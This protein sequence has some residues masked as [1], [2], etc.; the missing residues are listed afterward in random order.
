MNGI[1]LVSYARSLTH[2][3]RTPIIMLSASD[4]TLEAHR[5]GA[6]AFLRKPEDVSALAETIARLLSIE[7]K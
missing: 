6:N 5:A 4:Y 2:R 7:A 3:Q 1:K